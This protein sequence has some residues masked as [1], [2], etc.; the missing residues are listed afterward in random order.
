VNDTARQIPQRRKRQELLRGLLGLAAAFGFLTA[1]VA[2]AFLLTEVL[3]GR[4][5]FRPPALVL[6]LINTLLGLFLMAGIITIL[7]RVSQQKLIARQMGVFGPIIDAMAR[8][9]KGDFSVRLEDPPQDNPVVGALVKSVNTMALELN[10][11]EDMRQ[12]FIS[13][14]SH[15]IQSPLTSIRGFARALQN[16]EL[17]TADRAHYL[18]II[19]EE[20]VRLSR[21]SDNLLKLASLDADHLTLNPTPY[22]LDRQIRQIILACEPQWS[23]KCLTMDVSLD[24]VAITADE[25][26]VSQIWTNLL[27]NSIK[28]TP[29]SGSICIVLRQIEGNAIFTI[30]DTGIGIS[31]EDQARVFERFFKADASRERARGGSGLGLA[32]AQK[33]VALHQGAIEVG[34]ELGRGTVF[35]VR[36]PSAVSSQ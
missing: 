23:E 21:L 20:S 6:Q 36:L 35:T 24:D 32:I 5:G 8:I 17:S 25:D 3:F 16:E 14:V 28:F 11:L 34:S 19:A 4:I 30:A 27:H 31:Q 18:T 9:A 2:V 12:E 33:I 1:M 15:E 29:P 10:Q 7:T 13:N 22:R 26:M